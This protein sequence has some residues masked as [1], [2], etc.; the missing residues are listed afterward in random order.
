MVLG[1][2]PRLG[3]CP[4]RKTC[5]DL[6]SSSR[7]LDSQQEILPP[8]TVVLLPCLGI[9]VSIYWISVNFDIV[10]DFFMFFFSD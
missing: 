7:A 8:G 9:Y 4:H 6:P 2:P 3:R 10:K 5:P 1:L